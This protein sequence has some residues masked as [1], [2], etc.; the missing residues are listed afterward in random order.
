M[1]APPE[2]LQRSRAEKT[3]ETGKEEDC[4]VAE[5][6]HEKSSIGGCMFVKWQKFRDGVAAKGRRSD[7]LMGC[8]F[9]TKTLLA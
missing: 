1:P 4:S 7:A 9:H 2:L 6:Q 3:T 8:S 5:K